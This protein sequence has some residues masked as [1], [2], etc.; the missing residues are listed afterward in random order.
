[1]RKRETKRRP[2]QQT[3]TT[4]VRG[5]GIITNTVLTGTTPSSV[6]ISPASFPRTFAIGA[7]F[8]LFRFTSFHI[9]M[10]PVN[11]ASVTNSDLQW[12]SIGYADAASSTDAMTSARQV[13]ECIPSGVQTNANSAAFYGHHLPSGNFSIPKSDLLNQGL[14][15]WK[16]A[17]DSDSNVYDAIQFQLV[18]YN[19]WSTSQTFQIYVKY[20]IEYKGPINSLLTRRVFEDSSDVDHKEVEKTPPVSHSLCTRGAKSGRTDARGA[21]PFRG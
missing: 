21:L 1:M 3:T 14:K 11:I 6:P 19:S 18:Y 13:V 7:E 17:Q 4:R 15:W 2:S 10:L 16:C 12:W 20:V 9:T 8:Q 5:A